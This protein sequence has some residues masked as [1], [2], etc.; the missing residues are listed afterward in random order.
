MDTLN[1]VRHALPAAAAETTKGSEENPA[2]N[3]TT[4][5]NTVTA[6]A[7]EKL[8]ATATPPLPQ[9]QQPAREPDPQS[10]PFFMARSFTIHDIPTDVWV[11]LFADRTV[12]ACSQAGNGR[13]GNWL[14]CKRTV[15]D[16]S[17]L[18][19]KAADTHVSHLLG[20]T[21]R[22][23]PLLQVYAQ[24][25]TEQIAQATTGS[26]EDSSTVLLLGLSLDP[27]TSKDPAVF[28]TLI[29]LLGNVYRDAITMA[30]RRGA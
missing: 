4:A 14:L 3:T 29:Q 30:A 8:E 1:E 28:R 16:S 24:Q 5:S 12:L 17:M 27:L 13:I 25:V 26:E 2:S 21:Q 9:A 19:Q 22:D 23:D 15:V 10:L 11:Q 20:A 7:V 18:T 6:P